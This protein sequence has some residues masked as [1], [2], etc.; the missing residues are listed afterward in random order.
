MINVYIEI[1]NSVTLV[2]T[3]YMPAM[4]ETWVQED[5][6][7]GMATH[8]SI[9]AWK[10]PQTEEP[11]GLQ[12]MGSQRVGYNCATHVPLHILLY[13]MYIHLLI[14]QQPSCQCVIR[15]KR[16]N[17]SER[18]VTVIGLAIAITVKLRLAGHLCCITLCFSVF[19]I[20]VKIILKVKCP[21]TFINF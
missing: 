6:E 3:M 21:I 19:I 17:K 8:S 4:Q 15:T 9:L 12:F 14:P 10:T 2:Y 18:K 16:S 7:K 5:L 13:T 1:V 11:I 20:I